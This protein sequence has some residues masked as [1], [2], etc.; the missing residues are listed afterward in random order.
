VGN[1]QIALFF[2]PSQEPQLYAIDNWDCLARANII[3]R[4]IVAEMDGR[5]TV[6][7][8]LYKHHFCLSEGI[9]L[10]DEAV[11][12]AVYSAAFDG[13]TVLIAID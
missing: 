11:R 5:I 4:G 6:A 8:P 12:L 2:L 3:S 9:C 7:S 13:D 10:E 1:R